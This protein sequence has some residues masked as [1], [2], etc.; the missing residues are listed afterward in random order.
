MKIGLIDVDGHHFPNLALMKIASW[1][2]QQ[3]DD[4]EWAL[5]MFGHYNRIYAS[6]VFTFT[7]DFNRAAYHAEEI[8]RGGVL[9]TISSRGFLKK[10]KIIQGWLTTSIR[11]TRLACSS[12]L[13]AA[14]VIVLSVLCMIKREISIL[15]LRCSGILMR[16]GSRCWITT[17]L[18]IHNGVRR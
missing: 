12:T 13:A 14:S 2:R 5:P 16:S 17:S 18:P 8:I 10:L 4:V 7:P 15:S 3:G 9:A 6:K 1:H 11:N